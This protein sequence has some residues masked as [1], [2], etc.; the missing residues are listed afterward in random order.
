[1]ENSF[2][3]NRGRFCWYENWTR[4]GE[5]RRFSVLARQDLLGGGGGSFLVEAG[6][7]CF[8]ATGTDIEL[9]ASRQAPLV[10]RGE[11]MYA[12]KIQIYKYSELKTRKKMGKRLLLR[13]LSMWCTIIW[14]SPQ[15]QTRVSSHS[16]NLNRDTIRHLLARGSRWGRRGSTW[17]GCAAALVPAE[18]LRRQQN[19]LPSAYHQLAMLGS[20]CWNGVVW[21]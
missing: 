12:V 20:A 8:D 5:L 2:E 14:L 21:M 19:L 7:V 11:D 10:L 4:Y 1:M 15:A 3:A 18:A 16:H 6:C 9:L 13:K 17:S